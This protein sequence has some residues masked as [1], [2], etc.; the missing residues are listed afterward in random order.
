MFDTA[1]GLLVKIKEGKAKLIFKINLNFSRKAKSWK[2]EALNLVEVKE[3][4]NKFK[5]QVLRLIKYS[6]L[7][8]VLGKVVE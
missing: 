6:W 7:Y 5:I 2:G 4:S 1:L 8:Y 3:G